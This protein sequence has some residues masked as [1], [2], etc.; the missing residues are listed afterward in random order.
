MTNAQGRALVQQILKLEMKEPCSVL[1]QGVIEELLF[2]HFPNHQQE[3]DY[4][5][6]N[7]VNSFLSEE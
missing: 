4:W 1:T 2:E 6:E 7:S 3:F 5:F